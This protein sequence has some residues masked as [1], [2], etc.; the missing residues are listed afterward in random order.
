MAGK[1]PILLKLTEAA[2]VLRL[3]P[4]RLYKQARRG[5]IPG[6]VNLPGG[7]M[8]FDREILYRWLRETAEGTAK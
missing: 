3:T 6:T 1:V 5:K 4:E 2:L 8:R 7:E